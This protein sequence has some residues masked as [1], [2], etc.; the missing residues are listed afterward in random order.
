MRFDIIKGSH[1]SMDVDLTI[2]IC[3]SLAQVLHLEIRQ[4]YERTLLQHDTNKS[5]LGNMQVHHKCSCD[6]K[7]I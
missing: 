6:D 5:C 1:A 4:S 3:L 7:I 2:I